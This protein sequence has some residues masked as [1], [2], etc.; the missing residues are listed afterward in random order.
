MGEGDVNKG[1]PGGGSVW[2][3][4]STLTIIRGAPNQTLMNT[5]VGNTSPPLL[6]NWGAVSHRPIF[7]RKLG[8]KPDTPLRIHFQDRAMTMEGKAQGMMSRVR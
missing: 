3:A 2:R 6:K 4:E 5:R 7:T 1:L 8:R